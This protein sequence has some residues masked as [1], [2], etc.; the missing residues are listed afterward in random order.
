MSD[1]GVCLSCKRLSELVHKI[2]QLRNIENEAHL[3]NDKK[4]IQTLTDNRHTIIEAYERVLGWKQ[5]G[6]R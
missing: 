1:N 3:D 5:K 4:W 6:E 2:L